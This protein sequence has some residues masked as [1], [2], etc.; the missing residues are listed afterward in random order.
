MIRNVKMNKQILKLIIKNTIFQQ[1]LK[2]VRKN[3]KKIKKIF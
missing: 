1:K 3:N 2:N